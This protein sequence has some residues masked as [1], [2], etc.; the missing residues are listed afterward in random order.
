[1]W[2]LN[3][4]DFLGTVPKGSHGHSKKA[5]EKKSDAGLV[6][7]EGIIEQD[8]WSS[9][10]SQT[11]GAFRVG[12]PQRHLL[13]LFQKKTLNALIQETLQSR[14]RRRGPKDRPPLNSKMG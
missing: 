3:A 4:D 8:R 5:H 7:L 6:A 12:Y 10:N 14:R 11:A 1:M 2:Q 9:A 13:P